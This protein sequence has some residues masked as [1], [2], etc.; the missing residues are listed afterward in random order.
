MSQPQKP[1][2]CH[3]QNIEMATRNTANR[4]QPTTEVGRDVEPR[5]AGDEGRPRP[6][7]LAP[8]GFWHSRE[9]PGRRK[10]PAL[11]AANVGAGAC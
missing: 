11:P 10:K 1:Q 2:A 4:R 8:G 3:K 5:R 9:A 7:E 6:R